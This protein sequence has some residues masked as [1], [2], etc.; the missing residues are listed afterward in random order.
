MLCAGKGAQTSVKLHQIQ[1]P[2]YLQKAD[3]GFDE[4]IV[5]GNYD[6]QK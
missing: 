4:N 5:N 2:F 6:Y 1:G 3:S